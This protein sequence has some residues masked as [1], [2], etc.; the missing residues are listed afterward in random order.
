MRNDTTIETTML[1]V[2]GFRIYV[3]LEH[4]QGDESLPPLLLINGI[5]ANLELFDPFIEALDNVGEQKIATLRFDVPGIGKS[6]LPPRPLRL[7]GLTELIADMLDVLGH[8][9]VDVLGVSWGGG[10]AQQFAHQYQTRCRRLILASTSAGSLSVPGKPSV[11]VKMLS[12][13]RYL[14]PAYMVSIAPSLYG[15]VFRQNPDL[16]Q[17]YAQLITASHGLGYFGQL[18]AT[19]GWTSLPWLHQMRQPTLILAGKDDVIV[20]PLNARIMAR[21][22]PNATLHILNGGH[23]FILTE[24]EQVASLVYSFLRDESTSGK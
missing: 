9:V 2:K 8:P 15:D 17:S 1:N 22:I 21:L 11:L 6:P 19:V 10:L 14:D 4:Q 3:A 12:P 7:R 18:L 5:G 20:P 16:A 13:R 23:L 24:K